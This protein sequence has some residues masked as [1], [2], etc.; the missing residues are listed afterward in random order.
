MNEHT[1]SMNPF[2]APREELSLADVT[3]ARK[4]RELE[5]AMAAARRFPRDRRLS[6]ERILA[7]C[8]RRSLAESGLYSLSRGGRE[9]TGASI[10]LAEC[11]AQAWGNLDYGCIE[12]EQRGGTLRLMAYAWDLETNTRQSRVF[13]VQQRREGGEPAET[14]AAQAARRVRACILGLLPG[15][16]TEMAL[17]RCELTLGAAL[18]ET[19]LKARVRE[20]LEGFAACGVAEEQLEA[21]L[22]RETEDFD[23]EDALRLI[24][25][26]GSLRDGVIGADFFPPRAPETGEKRAEEK[27]TGEK[28]AE[29]K[30]TRAK[31]AAAKKAGPAGG[32]VKLDD[33]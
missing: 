16:V 17:R 8:S 23:G 27:N 30:R 2:G 12:L 19:P 5:A 15:D 10:R 6:C 14:A 31:R 3:A 28:S 9:I 26:L 29:P 20:L 24:R 1:E 11:L 22:G 21:L 33:L 18:G 32:E 25:L 7:D 4:D 13:T